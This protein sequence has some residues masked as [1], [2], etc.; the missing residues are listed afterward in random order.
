MFLAGASFACVA[1][2][3]M[4]KLAAHFNPTSP[5]AGNHSDTLISSSKYD[6]NSNSLSTNSNSGSEDRVLF[7]PDTGLVNS[8][9]GGEAE[10]P[11]SASTSLVHMLDALQ[12]ARRSLDVCMYV[13]TC[14][15]LV[16]HMIAAKVSYFV[17]ITI[18][19]ITNEVP[20]S[21]HI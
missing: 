4:R 8:A 13:L 15:P 18:L 14:A 3:V 9:L 20:I 7:F 19:L 6:S 16:E 17:V 1:F 12:S 2:P 10:S 11:I 5:F 21:S